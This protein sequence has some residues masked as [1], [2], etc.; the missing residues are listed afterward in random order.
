M[1][2]ALAAAAA[3]AAAAAVCSGD[4]VSKHNNDK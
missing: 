4:S 3:A 1:V 2:A